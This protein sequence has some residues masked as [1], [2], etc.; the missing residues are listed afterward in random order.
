[1]EGVDQAWRYTDP[2]NPFAIY[3]KLNKGNYTFRVKATDKNRLWSN[4]ITTLKIYKEPH[5]YETWWA[6]TLYVLLFILI[7]YTIFRFIYHKVE[8]KNKLKIAQIEKEKSEELTQLKLRYFTNI[9]H[10]ILTPL[11]II[12]CLVDDAETTGSSFR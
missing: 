9:T 4:H 5:F 12:S 11:T 2:G 1:M 10:D 6:Y 3:N 8:L 7:F